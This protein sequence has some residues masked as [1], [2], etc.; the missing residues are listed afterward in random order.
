MLVWTTLVAVEVVRSYQIIRITHKNGPEFSPLILLSF[1]IKC[2]VTC[3]YSFPED[4]GKHQ[5][6]KKLVL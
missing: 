3:S 1:I 5:K 6:F 2:F 4:G